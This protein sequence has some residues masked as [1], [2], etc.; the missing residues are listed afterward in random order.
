MDPYVGEIRIFAGNFA[1]VGWALCNGQLLSIRSNA[2]LYSIIGTTYGGDGK[3]TFALPNMQGKAPIHQGTGVSLSS[4]SIGSTGGDETVT[5]LASE[6][7]A[8]THAPQFTKGANQEK[9]SPNLWA[10]S[11]KK[12][13]PNL[14]Q[15]TADVSMSPSTVQRSGG[16]QAHNNMQP[17]LVMNY[18]ISLEGVYP[19][20]S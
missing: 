12:P 9:P 20:R 8:H 13:R 18:I 17:Y 7:P 15:S 19:P 14:Y 16:N 2:P 10:E 4:Y 6:I 11:S 1:P 3:T 5:L